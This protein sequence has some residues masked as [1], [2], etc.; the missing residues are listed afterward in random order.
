MRDMQNVIYQ[1]IKDPSAGLIEK[2]LALKLAKDTIEVF[3]DEFIS[4]VQ[5]SLLPLLEKIAVYKAGNNNPDRGS[6]IF[7]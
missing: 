6:T 5:H 2:F 4:E 7:N 3:N 1:V